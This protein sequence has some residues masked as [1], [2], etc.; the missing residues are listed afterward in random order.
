[1]TVLVSIVFLGEEDA[2]HLK[3]MQDSETLKSVTTSLAV[4]E[5]TRRHKTGAALLVRDE[6]VIG[7]AQIARGG[8]ADDIRRRLD[9]NSVTMLNTSTARLDDLRSRLYASQHAPTRAPG[10][11]LTSNAS[12]S[13]R[14]WLLDKHPEASTS[15]ATAGTGRPI[16]DNARL[17]LVAEQQEA[18]T[19]LLAFAQLDPEFVLVPAERN[20]DKDRQTFLPAHK[21]TPHEDALVEHD[22]GR[23]LGW[24]A[25]ST[26][27]VGIR[28]FTDG[29]GRTLQVMNANR[30]P[31]ESAVGTDLIYYHEQRKSFVLVQYKRMK[32]E[33]RSWIYRPDAQLHKQLDT[34]KSVDDCCSTEDSDE[35]RLFQTPSF[36]KICKLES[37]NLESRSL[38]P[39][40]YLAREQVEQHIRAGTKGPG[41]GTYFS[42]ENAPNYLTNT[43]FTDLVA[44]GLI[45]SR[46]TDTDFIRD[47]I[48]SSLEQTGSTVVGVLSDEKDRRPG[49]SRQA[50]IVE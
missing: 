49:P 45:G 5:G 36:V 27:V 47:Q 25:E 8:R 4:L 18:T 32:S 35:F 42:F 7:A 10:G 38:V 33:T 24:R 15:F 48:A 16:G 3:D 31:A 11:A 6:T 34:M 26:D 17:A 20:P 46:G 13:A 22:V 23:F 14:Q 9:L 21:V 41:G 50:K 12:E 43:L 19:A 29:V 39:G 40:M 2:K 1:M 37:L 28:A 30:T 44:Q